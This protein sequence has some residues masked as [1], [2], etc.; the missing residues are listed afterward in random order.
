MSM[1]NTA[2]AVSRTEPGT[3]TPVKAVSVISTGTV[4][5]RPEHA[6]GSRKPLY[7]W[8]LT[9]R[10]WTRPR[11]INVYVIEHSRGLVLFDA[12]QD[13]HSVTSASYFPGGFTGVIYDRLA[14]FHMGEEDTLSAQL[15]TLGYQAKNVDLAILSHLHQ[16]HIGGLRELM[17]ADILVSAA[18]W[19]E[20]SKL[21]PEV[22]GFLRKHIQIPGLQWRQ[23][24]LEPTSDPTLAPFTASLDVMGDGSLILLPTPG[25]TAGSM[26]LLV[27]RGTQSPLLLVGDLTYGAELLERRQVPGVGNRRQLLEAT[28]KVLALKRMMPDLVILPAHDPTAAERLHAS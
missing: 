26:A 21:V 15:A 16:D 12:G 28:D 23:V 19:A 17:A 4:E 1:L 13:R 27:R 7:W 24:V 18:E 6:F 3:P 14:R 10:T 2:T 8:L 22:R 9:S 5:I 11:P 25:H 20:L